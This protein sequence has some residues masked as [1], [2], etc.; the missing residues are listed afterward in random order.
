MVQRD[1]LD[2]P[3]QVPLL[4]FYADQAQLFAADCAIAYYLFRLALFKKL[5]HW[6]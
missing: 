6:L 2:M 3:G 4:A 5:N 1:G